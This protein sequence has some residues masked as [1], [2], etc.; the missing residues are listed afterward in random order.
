MHGTRDRPSSLQGSSVEDFEASR[1][2]R[3]CL[4]RSPTLHLGWPADEWWHA[5]MR[6][7]TV[8]APS[9]AG[10]AG[11]QKGVADAYLGRF[12]KCVRE[13]AGSCPQAGVRARSPVPA[14]GCVL[15]MQTLLPRS[16]SAE[17]VAAPITAIKL[18]DYEYAGINCVAYDIANHWCACCR[19][20][21][22]PLETGQGVLQHA[23]SRDVCQR[24]ALEHAMQC[25]R[26]ADYSTS[27]RRNNNE[28]RLRSACP[29]C[30]PD[31]SPV[32][33]RISNLAETTMRP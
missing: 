3:S 30:C 31:A 28:H 32:D 14:Q 13:T 12:G 1:A 25:R 8:D 9:S 4:H 24:Q 2:A 19:W 33:M 20:R 21:T 11:A 17:W 16:T 15:A 10:S 6:V 23:S 22:C 27:F 29:R 5:H 26:A 7:C 18:I